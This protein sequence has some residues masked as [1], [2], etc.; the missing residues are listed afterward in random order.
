MKILTPQE[1]IASAR[2][3]LAINFPFYGS[4]FLR[5]KVFEDDTMPTAYTDGNVIGYNPNYLATL[6]HEQIIGVFVHECLH[7]ILKHPLRA[8][9]NIVFKTNHKRWNYA[10]DYALNPQIK[11]TPGM[12]IHDSWLYDPKWDDGLAEEIFHELP[13]DE[14]DSMYGDFG[15]QPGEVRPWPGDGSKVDGKPAIVTP[16]D[17]DA[18]KQ[19]I[20][21]WVKAAEFKAQG[22]GKMDG[23][24]GAII[25]AATKSTVDWLDEIQLT[26]E[27]I[28]KDDY[29]W[30]RPNVRYMQQGVYL[31]S[32]KGH[33]PV[34]MIFY[35]DVSGSLGDNQLRQIASEIQTVVGG[36][37]IRVIVVY[38]STTFKGMEIFDASDVLEPGFKLTATGRGGTDFTDCWDWMFD[39]EVE[40]DLD[41]K[42]C[43]FFSD[44]E[45]S[46]Y[47]DE[48]PGM[49]VL[50]AH[51]P[52]GNR[53]ITSY[54]K[55]LPD[56]GDRV[57]VPV[58]REG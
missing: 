26:C 12:N 57:K 39:N 37:N 32:M 4:I 1:R 24:T 45:C 31:P 19:E 30:T 49:P 50:W 58:Y 6:S 35:V 52:C 28:C 9:E 34:D 41:P 27:D 10:C 48:D 8:A 53:F 43:I 55:Y 20:D 5:L 21:Q 16:A 51:V 40:F 13:K 47:P 15:D 14:L 25:K 54:L 11:R 2:L 22:V 42:A 46:D 44:L 7:V 56:Y 36:F 18:K 3:D 33:R 38:W 23:N 29:S 17:I